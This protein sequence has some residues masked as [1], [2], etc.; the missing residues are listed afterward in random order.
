LRKQHKK[1]RNVRRK[2]L[3]AERNKPR[4]GAAP[5]AELPNVIKL[6]AKYGV[7]DTAALLGELQSDAE[8][9]DQAAAEVLARHRANL[10]AGLESGNPLAA[11]IMAAWGEQPISPEAE[12]VETEG[13]GPPPLEPT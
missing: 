7:E 6:A 5:S 12:E 8:D 10:H 13:R 9:G 3:R 1:P 4:I 2:P 11:A